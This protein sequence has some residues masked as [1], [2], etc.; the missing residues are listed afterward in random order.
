MQS[1]RLKVTSKC[2]WQC[3]FC[4]DEGGRATTN[5]DWDNSLIHAVRSLQEVLPNIG[6]VHY[7]VGEPTQNDL[8]PLISNGLRSMD[9]EIKTTTNG[10]FTKET[11]STLMKSGLRSFN[12]SILSL[13]P[14]TFL[15]TQEGRGVSWESQTNSKNSTK[16]NKATNLNWA[17]KQIAHQQEMIL[18]ARS[19]GAQVKTNTVVSSMTGINNALS[20]FK[21]AKENRIPFRFLNDLSTGDESIIAI[22]FIIRS[23]HAI[24]ISNKRTP[25]SSAFSTINITPD[26]FE[27]RFKQIKENKLA[28][29]CQNCPRAEN[30]TCQEQFYGIRLQKSPDGQ[31]YVIL[32]IQE[33]NN[34]TQM[35]LDDFLSSYQLLEIQSST[36]PQYAWNWRSALKQTAQ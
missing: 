13:D 27:F 33:N 32:C 6:E 12:F 34:K 35:P 19:L 24:H 8:L 18:Y 7:T 26:G 1:I 36:N 11:L 21:W 28:S 29:M 9:L 20:I 30:N 14:A 17:K 31:F 5:L 22:K 10:Q 15:S 16:A 2:P 23:L 25:G 3:T 4:H